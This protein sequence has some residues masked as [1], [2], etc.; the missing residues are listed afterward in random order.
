MT[1]RHRR[2]ALTASAALGLCGALA[3]G[4]A[5][6]QEF[7]NFVVFGDSLVDSGQRIDPGK[8]YPGFP[9]ALPADARWR[10]TNR[11]TGGEYGLPYSNQ[12][13][14][15]LGFGPLHP[16][17]PQTAPGMTAEGTGLNY[18]VGG[19]TASEIRAQI[20]TVATVPA[21]PYYPA[22][23]T[24]PG[25]LVG[26]N[27]GLAKGSTLALVSSGGNDVRDM[28]NVQFDP[29]TR[30]PVGFRLGAAQNVVET[31][32]AVI[33][34]N[35]GAEMSAAALETAAGVK[36]LRAAGVGLVIVPNV[37]N[38]ANTPETALLDSQAPALAAGLG[39][40]LPLDSPFATLRNGASQAYNG[41]LNAALAEESGVMRVDLDGFFTA[42]LA[43]PAKFGFAAV[44]QSK[45]CYNASEFTGAP[46]AADP[47]YGQNLTAGQTG[48]P[49]ALLFND[50][51]HPTV[52]AHAAV[53]DVIQS[54][55]NAP[56]QIAH[57]PYLGL[58]AARDLT[59][60]FEDAAERGARIGGLALFGSLGGGL[61]DLDSLGGRK[62][63][64]SQTINGSFGATKLLSPTLTLGAGLGYH[65]VES[66]AAEAEIDGSVFLGGV[67]AR[68]DSGALFGSATATLGYADVDLDR[69]SR[70][71]QA[72]L[73]NSGSSDGWI[74][75]ASVEA[76]GRLLEGPG[77]TAGPLARLEGYA[78]ELGGYTESGPAYLAQSFGDLKAQSFRGGIG[79]FA[80]AWGPNLGG[81]IEALYTH[82]FLDGRD[83]HTSSAALGGAGWSAPGRAADDDGLQ[84]GLT[85]L[86]DLGFGVASAGYTGRF[87][88]DESHGFRFG[89][90]MPF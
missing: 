43:D 26:P 8:V 58:G 77:F 49:Y 36:A 10:Y 38:L 74:F 73:K 39:L 31:D 83:I 14:E 20:E 72:R 70:V 12:L 25:F 24:G 76:G 90:S 11:V 44:D 87:G 66:D 34:R 23:T 53:A 86:A 55:L 29:T 54:S 67:T 61:G 46:C 52:G 22:T 9:I 82:E 81:R 30:A 60:S 37:P 71:G 84:L 68:H 57:A 13:A 56:S 7:K 85:A 1:T 65:K 33:Q 17:N 78:G 79:A 75:G 41:A 89:L 3:A 47:T 64:D 51:I 4:G 2:A 59:S 45:V 21:T 27:A 63:G 62:G 15:D 16:S 5:A 18:A 42:A 19:A 88:D 32:M 35:I 40:T 48:N 28:A 50:G 69:F 80:E 6:A